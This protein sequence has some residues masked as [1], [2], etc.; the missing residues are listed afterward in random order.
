MGEKAEFDNMSLAHYGLGHG[1]VVGVRLRPPSPE[2]APGA[3][4]GVDTGAKDSGAAETVG[5]G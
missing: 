4:A 1:G 5:G 2:E 3:N